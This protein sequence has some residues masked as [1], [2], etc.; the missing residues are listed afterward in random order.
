MTGSGVGG[1]FSRTRTEHESAAVA[2]ANAWH[3]RG[4]WLGV[5]SRLCAFGHPAGFPVSGS[6]FRDVCRWMACCVAWISICREGEWVRRVG[7]RV[8]SGWHLFA[9]PHGT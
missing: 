5:F 8:R 3:C 7:D 6:G 4:A 9:H 1:T 2:V